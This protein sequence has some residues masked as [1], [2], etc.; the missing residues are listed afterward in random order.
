ML[1]NPTR[2]PVVLAALVAL[3]SVSVA[4]VSLRAQRKDDKDKKP[5][6][7][8]TAAQRQEAAPLAKLADE[9]M[10][11]AA[12]G[13]YLVTPPKDPQAKDA[14]DAKD[15][16]SQTAP[17]IPLTFRQDFLKAQQGLIFVPF[18]VSV[19]PGKLGSSVA[20]YLRIA[21]KAA[22]GLPAPAAGEKAPAYPFEDVYFTELR[23]S[24]AGQP[25]RLTRAFAVAPGT[26]DVYL[27]LRERPTGST[28]ADAPVKVAML[29][30]ELVVPNYHTE[31][32]QT[33]SLLIA[34]KIEPLTAPIA[35]EAM[36]ERPYV[37][38]DSEITP[39]ADLKFKKSEEL[40]LVFQIYGAKLGA[41]KKPDVSI[42]YVFFQKEAAGEKMFNKT[43]TQVLNGES[44]PKNFD[45]EMG[46]QLMTGQGVPLQ[47]FPEGDYRLEI[48]IN[49]NKAQKSVTRDVLFTVQAAS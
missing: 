38:G 22:T 5:A 39:A 21:P 35:A 47:S 31:E 19:E 13:T 45:P 33:S 29:K 9:V 41:D 30:Q 11:G 3:A 7:G 14:K 26:Y 2:T 28:A 18:S 24:G 6:E 40:Q 25:S 43:P 16:P 37:L 4:S 12:A 48:K 17:E 23:S 20:A 42:D 44:L 1:S 27:A 32:L 49:D 8:L 15:V 10:K 36:K 34:D 46:H